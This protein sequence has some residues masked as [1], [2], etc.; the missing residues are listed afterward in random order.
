MTFL[1]FLERFRDPILSGL[2][3][4][5]TRSKAYGKAGDVLDTPFGRVRL[6]K[7]ERRALAYVRDALW[8]EEGVSS[9]VEFERIW[10]EIHTGRGFREDDVRYVHH[11]QK[12]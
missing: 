3:T 1:P 9:P 10:N 12:L 2:K 7:V 8:R 6:V 11:F 5:T 4:V